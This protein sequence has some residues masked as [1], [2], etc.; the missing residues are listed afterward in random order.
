MSVSRTYDFSDA[1]DYN[2]D[3][4]YIEPIPEPVYIS[5]KEELEKY[6]SLVEH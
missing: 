5:F 3:T 1:N 2:F 4:N 6:V